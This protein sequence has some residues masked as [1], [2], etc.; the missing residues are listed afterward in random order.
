[1]ISISLENPAYAMV[2]V[3]LVFGEHGTQFL[4]P[5]ELTLKVTGLDLE[6]DDDEGDELPGLGLYCYDPIQM[7]WFPVAFKKCKVDYDKGTVRGTWYLE[8]F[9]R[10]SLAD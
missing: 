9:S 2:S 5:A 4:V 7:A 8:H 10:Y 1:M 6:G 3:D